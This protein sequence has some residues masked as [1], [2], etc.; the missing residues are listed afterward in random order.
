[1]ARVGGAQAG[2][3]TGLVGLL[4]RDGEAI[5]YDLQGLGLSVADVFTGRLTLRRLRD[6]LGSMPLA[7]TALWRKRRREPVEG[8]KRPVDPPDDWWTPELDMLA[9]VRDD[10][11]HLAWMQT[12]DGAKGRNHPSPIPRPGVERPNRY[13]KPMTAAALLALLRPERR[14]AGADEH[15]AAD[16]AERAQDD[17]GDGESGRSADLHGL[18]VAE[19]GQH[20]SGEG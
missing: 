13:G 6:L 3:I 8:G 18:S 2:G 5:D 4:E 15:G 9:G 17:P 12:K 7:G 10:L 19:H 16:D 20:E 11:H 1:M 14:D